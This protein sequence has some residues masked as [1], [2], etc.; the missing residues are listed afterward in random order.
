ML[1]ISLSFFYVILISLGLISFIRQPDVSSSKVPNSTLVIPQEGPADLKITNFAGPDLTP[2]PACLAVA[3]TGEVYVGVDMIGS[4]GKD[5]GKGSIVRLVD[6]NNDGTVDQHTTFAQVDNPRGIISVGD[7]VFV[8][9]T[10]FSKETGKASGMDLVVFEDK[11]HDGVADGS[12]KPLIQGIS[13]PKFLQSRGTDHA[14]NGIRMGIDGWIYIAV[15]DFGF[16]DAVDR[17]GKKL[18]MLGGGIVRVRPNGTE[19][20]VY[21]HGMRNIYDVAIDPY[22]NIFTR[23][24][25]N[26]GGGWNIRFSHQ[27]QS[28][29]YGYPVLF[30]HFTDEIIPALVDLGGGSGAGSLFLD[31]PTWPEKY[32]RVPLMADWGRSM[33]YVHR[34]TPDGPSFRQKDEEFIKLPQITD[35]DVDGS[36]RMYLSAW[37]G[38]GYSGNPAKGYVVRAVPANWTYKPFP[39]LKKASVKQLVNLLKSES[40]VARL[41]AQQELLTRPAK[42]TTKAV[43]KMVADKSLPLYARVA[44]LYTY[45]QATGEKG[46]ADLVK[47]T[48]E[49]DMR[50]FA[51]R[52]LSDRK[53]H[54]TGVPVE[55]FLKGLKDPS[56]RVQTASIIGL[57]RLGKP[58]A[59]PALLQIKVPASFVA[60]AKDVEGPHATPNSTIIP[61]HFAMRALVSLNA[62]DA[63]VNAIG[64]ENS[65]LALWTLRYFHDSKAVDG[66]I[67][68]YG[69][70]K[71]ENLKN[72][73]LVTLSRLYKKEAPYDASWWWGTRPDSHGP[74]YKGIT[75]EASPKIEN[76]LKEQWSKADASDKQLYADLNSRHRM[77]ITEFG[78]EDSLA[79]KDD[80]KVDL[81]KIRNQKGQIGK[82]SIEDVM[83]AIAKIKGD[84][85]VGKGLFTRQGCVA[86]HSIKKGEVLKGPFMGQIGSIMNR[87]QIAESVLKPN[88]SISQGFATVTISAKGGKSYTGF[89]SEETADKVVMR[90]IAG[91]VFTIKTSDIISRKEMET[92]MMPSGLAN[93]LSY[94]EFASLITFLSEQKK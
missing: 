12:S 34:V 56:I 46:N 43:W 61:A 39:D 86:C 48:H 52:A 2:S 60:P 94:E 65:T 74:Y 19:M 21:T 33:L 55:P 28:G 62:V 8:L 16:H 24:N 63:C 35:V 38:A 37:D 54:I 27:I 15:G 93:A 88:A 32:N 29:E 84:P 20:E 50:E 1:R 89:V 71:D 73:I 66:L 4:L 22:M 10:T 67:K 44:G 11:N 59:I 47:L 5:P 6:S 69:Q 18:T 64:T 85:V 87:E 70:A 81:E 17:S 91:E 90:N 79:A 26:D 7:Q 23:G 53:T 76:F 92:S 68:A 49:N 80:I 58:E 72:Q 78:G 45:T 13:N 31:E 42:S 77:G 3:P 82:S 51:L 14:T 40:A 57:G 41:Y 36:G 9:H 30:Q 83:L 75:W 25:T